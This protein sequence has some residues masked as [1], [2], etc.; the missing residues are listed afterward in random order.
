T[1]SL[2]TPQ[3]QS[4]VAI[5]LI[6]L[7]HL[8]II[9]RQIWPVFLVLVLREDGGRNIKF[10][11]VLILIGVLSFLYAVWDYTRY[12]F[13]VENNELC[14]RSGIFRRKKLNVPFDRIQSVDFKQNL[15]HQLLNVV[16]VQVDTAGSKGSEL[17]LDAIDPK[18]A[19][20]LREMVMDYKR[21]LKK[22]NEASTEI[23]GEITPEVPAFQETSELLLSLSPYDLIKV[24]IS[25]NHLRS[26]AIIF[27]FLISLAD[28]LDQVMGWNIFNGIGETTSAMSVF[29]LL[30]F[31]LAIPFFIVL[32]F[33]ITLVGM[34]LKYYDLK[35][36]RTGPSFKVVAGLL[37][38]TEKT[39]QKSKIQIMQW[40]TSPL[41]K[42]F[43]L[44][45]FTI[46][47]ATPDVRQN[48]SLFIP[49][50][51]QPQLDQTLDV[52]VPGFRDA[53]FST[54]KM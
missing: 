51:Y 44:F 33:I 46:F 43:G 10:L 39:I 54:H 35:F 2:Y 24:G 26:A 42:L 29:G 48:K 47:Q 13:F 32:S 41:K 18:R 8:R 15:V 5:L 28:D 50:C 11:S 49:G 12:Y 38:R 9:A 25:R 22:T 6:L 14:V 37:T 4:P 45:Q 52:I 1:N 7:R 19:N 36:W 16:R 17:E 40:D 30:L 21:S 23:E 3:R 31:L 53:D 34:V 20:A 27:A